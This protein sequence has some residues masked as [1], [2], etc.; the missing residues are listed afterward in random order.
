MVQFYHS[1]SLRF[2]NKLPEISD[3]V[4][5]KLKEWLEPDLE[6]FLSLTEQEKNMVHSIVEERYTEQGKAKTEGMF[7]IN[8]ARSDLNSDGLSFAEF[9]EFSEAYKVQR[10]RRVKELGF[11]ENLDEDRLEA[12]FN[13]CK[14]ISE[15]EES[16]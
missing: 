12:F 3:D 7:N 10:D 5:D 4:K 6:K 1:N 2:K 14:E 13:I 11:D 8:F 9:L 15:N 16:D